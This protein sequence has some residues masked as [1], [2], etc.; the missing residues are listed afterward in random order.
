MHEHL[1]PAHEAILFTL[2]AF[3]FEF[4]LFPFFVGDAG[5]D[6]FIGR[7]FFLFFFDFTFFL[8]T[9]ALLDMFISLFQE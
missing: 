6:L 5:H 2:L 4:L 7:G 8:V 1:L 9:I 3:L